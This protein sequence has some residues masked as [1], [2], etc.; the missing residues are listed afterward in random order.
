MPLIYNIVFDIR[1][2]SLIK[3]NTSSRSDCFTIMDVFCY[4]PYN[5]SDIWWTKLTNSHSFSRQPLILDLGANLGYTSKY[6]KSL[7]P[8]AKIIG[9]E[10]DPAAAKIA[11]KNN[12]N[13]VL[14]GAISCGDKAF[15]SKGD[16]S[17]QVRVASSGVSVSVLDEEFLMKEMTDYSPFILKVDIEGSENNLFDHY[18]NLIAKFPVIFVELHD[19]MSTSHISSSSIWQYLAR[20][21]GLY[22][23]I[24]NGDVLCLVRTI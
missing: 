11:R 8:E 12:N 6:L 15:I 17:Y 22:H 14:E 3:L 9:I 16:A 23:V 1:K 13:D 7:F 18:Q 4:Q 24:I 2:L 5:L 10:P 21:N 20:N 19:W